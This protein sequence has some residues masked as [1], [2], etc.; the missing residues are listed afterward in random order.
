VVFPVGVSRH[1]LNEELH[2]DVDFYFDGAYIFGVDVDGECGDT[3]LYTV[4]GEA[5][6]GVNGSCLGGN[7]NIQFLNLTFKKAK[8]YF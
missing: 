3:K 7:V 4:R 2:F 8:V 1:A 6:H 5:G